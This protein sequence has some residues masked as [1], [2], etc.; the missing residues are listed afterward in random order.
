MPGPGYPQDGQPDS[1]PPA[2][3]LGG[4]VIALAVARSLSKAGVPVTALGHESDPIRW[5]RH[6][7]SFVDVGAGV[8]SQGRFLEWLESGPGHGVVLPCN[9]DALELVAVEQDGLE[10]AGY[11]TPEA[12]G[13]TVRDLLDKERTYD[14]AREGGIPAPATITLHNAVDLREVEGSIGFPCALK[15]L[16]SHH[17][18]EHF[19]ARTKVLVVNDRAE[20]ERAFASLERVGVAALATEIVPGP[21]RYVSFY[22]YLDEDGEPLL[23]LTKQKLR[24]SPPFFG[25]GA[26]HV[27]DWNPEVAEAGLR[28]LRAVG[29]RGLA[30]VEFKRDARDGR[31]I[32]IESNPRFSAATELL[33]AAGLDVALI[34]YNRLLGRPPPV[35]GPYE[36]GLHLWIP[37]ADIRAA[38]GYRSAGELSLRG[39]A[40]SLMARQRFPVASLEDPGALLGKL[41]YKLRGAPKRLRRRAE[42]AR[43]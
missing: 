2:I 36:Q 33:H 25:L 30:V 19:G 26:Y 8:E 27:T 41:A 5:S 22:G 35:S 15:P 42:E 43:N 21:D 13:S 10:R 34:T 9:D 24:Q 18:A 39:W 20:L 40:R 7:E 23:Q 12:D 4:G 17:F 11:I 3:L 28:F 16:H 31:L 1:N 38:L 37:A 29:L 32:L 6:R 14:L